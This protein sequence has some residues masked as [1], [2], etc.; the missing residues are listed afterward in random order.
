MLL[1]T[2][3]QAAS[4][5]VLQLYEIHEG[6][7][8]KQHVRVFEAACMH[9]EHCEYCQCRAYVCEL[10][11]HKDDLLFPFQETRI[12]KVRPYTRALFDWLNDARCSVTS[13]RM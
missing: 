12:H 3:A 9:I 4:C 11:P 10:C 6:S 1:S 5:C 2:C 13:A 8:Q 7:L